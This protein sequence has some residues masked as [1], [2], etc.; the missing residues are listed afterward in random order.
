MYCNHT[1]AR[2]MVGVGG[3]SLILGWISGDLCSGGEDSGAQSWGVTCWD[4]TGMTIN[5][6]NK[7]ISVTLN[8]MIV[9][10]VRSIAIL[11]E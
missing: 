4:T 8:M 2:I 3:A 5:G 7:D 6:R 10:F 11:V 1:R 9:Y